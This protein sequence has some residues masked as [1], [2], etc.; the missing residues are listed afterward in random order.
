M[1]FAPQYRARVRLPAEW[2]PQAG[3]ML[4]WPHR[5]GDWGDLLPAAHRAMADFAAVVA[6]FQPLLIVCYDEPHQRSIIEALAER[7]V[8]PVQI[9]FV[10]CPSNDVWARDHG[11]LTVYREGA[12]PLLLDFSF[13]GWGNK[14][15]AE[16]DNQLVRR[17]HAAGAFGDV[18]YRRIDWVLEGGAI[19]SDGQGT[20]L[21]TRRCLLDENRS[22]DLSQQQVEILLRDWLGAQ[23]VL[24]LEHGEL[25]G[26]DTDGH[27]DM[28]ARFCSVD[29]IAY[30]ACD[31]PG[32]SHYESLQA[33]EAELRSLRT[34]HGEPYRLLP[35][36]WPRPAHADDGHRLPLSY[37]NFLIVNG[38]VI[39]PAYDDPADAKA[40]AVLQQAFPDREVIPSPAL[41]IIVQ[42]GSLHCLSMQLPAGIELPGCG[43]T[44]IAS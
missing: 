1:S 8:S 10:L 14:F 13:N 11:P 38:G 26:D 36:P 19:E 3:T 41:P 42:H 29:T 30:T 25:E 18:D 32:D 39:V 35:L 24:W 21:T 17:L 44:L 27:I 22:P 23:R 16:L 2:E 43:R 6:R 7:G 34:A 12:L 5:Y 40:I 9:S 31:D 20:I 28:L 33:M 4:T 37:A 15:P